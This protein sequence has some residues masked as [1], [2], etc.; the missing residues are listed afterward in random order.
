MG[1]LLVVAANTSKEEDEAS[2]ENAL[3]RLQD[4]LLHLLLQVLHL[5]F[6]LLAATGA[7]GKRFYQRAE[8]ILQSLLCMR[9]GDQQEGEED[10]LRAKEELGRLQ[11]KPRHLALVLA[12]LEGENHGRKRPCWDSLARILSWATVGGVECVSVYDPAGRVKKDQAELLRALGRAR[13]DD[14]ADMEVVWRGHNG[15]RGGEEEE[16]AEEEDE[17]DEDE[18]EVS[19]S[20]RRRGNGG[21]GTGRTKV[22]VTVC[23]LAEED[24]KGDIARAARRL[25]RRVRRGSIRPGDIDE[26]SV[27]GVL[28]TCRGLPDPDLLLLF[29][30]SHR[31]SGGF[32]PWQ[33]R[34]TEMHRLPSHVGLRLAD[35][36]SVMKKFS[37][38]ERRYG[39]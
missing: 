16:E 33:V 7:G 24:G 2:S 23:V 29:G 10:L 31:G 34:L 1:D 21:N 4:A 5:L 14:L 22:P 19:L 17:E 35:F 18:N 9:Q 11:K 15:A 36:M 32:P 26:S 6:D 25:A 37:E 13:F 39:K 12:D 20:R 3:V 38:C 27:S 30:P 8:G 28:S